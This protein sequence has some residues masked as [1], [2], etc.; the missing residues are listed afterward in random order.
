MAKN[1]GVSFY[2]EL[3]TGVAV[4]SLTIFLL[5]HIPLASAITILFIP[6]PVF[7][8]FSKL[9]RAPGMIILALS[10]LAV[11]AGTAV[12][13]TD[14]AF[15]MVVLLGM[16]GFAM[17][18]VVRLGYP[19]ER[20]I[21]ISSALFLGAGFLFLVIE[22][23]Q[24]D[25]SIWDS[26]N[27][28]MTRYIEANIEYYGQLDTSSEQIALLKENTGRIVDIFLM[29]FPSL[30]LVSTSILV[31][32]NLL[33]A[34]P[35]FQ[36]TALPFPDYGDLTRWRASEKIVWFVILAGFLVLMADGL[37]KVIGLNALLLLAPIYLLNGL[38]VTAFFQ[39]RLKVP[40][41]FGYFFYLALFA[42]PHAMI[43]I[44]AVGLIDVWIDF[45]KRSE[46]QDAPTP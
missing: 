9:G 8:Y 26:M 19:I 17:S 16:L 28:Y 36:K 46:Q 18:E 34:R 6:L 10:M 23:W 2:T 12:A 27:M 32:L 1:I 21:I 37:F 31:L 41:L 29:L 14:A 11:L 7:Y 38:A 15:P 4:T 40:R 44:I 24:E 43:G 13:Q 30:V 5:A 3:L 33:A 35:I 25:L 39:T 42:I 20:T 22:G 45:R